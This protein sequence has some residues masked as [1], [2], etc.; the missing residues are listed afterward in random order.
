MAKMIKKQLQKI[1]NN[2]KP[3]NREEELKVSL[4]SNKSNENILR[5]IPECPLDQNF[6]TLIYAVTAMNDE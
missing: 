1:K 5:I 2:Q 4:H 6:D 3:K